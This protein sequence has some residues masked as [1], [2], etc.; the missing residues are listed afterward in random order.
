MK[1]C[2]G[3]MNSAYTWKHEIKKPEVVT[4]M[5]R[6]VIEMRIRHLEIGFRVHLSQ[7]S[8]DRHEN[9]GVDVGISS[10]DLPV[11]EMQSTSGCVSAMLI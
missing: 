7:W 5:H 1:L 11:S 4:T 10:I 8:I 6:S 2:K 3:P 9:V